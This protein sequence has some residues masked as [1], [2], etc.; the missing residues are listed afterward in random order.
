[1]GLYDV[2]E[3]GISCPELKITSSHSS[4]AYLNHE[5]KIYLKIFLRWFVFPV[6]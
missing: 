1:M 2:V 4:V 3:G 6:L 5:R